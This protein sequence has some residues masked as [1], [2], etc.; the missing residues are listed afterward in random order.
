MQCKQWRNIE[1]S[2]FDLSSGHRRNLTVGEP[3]E[4]NCHIQF[5]QRRSCYSF[6]TL[7]GLSAALAAFILSMIRPLCGNL[8]GEI[9]RKVVRTLW[10]RGWI[11]CHLFHRCTVTWLALSCTPHPW[12]TSHSRVVANIMRLAKRGAWRAWSAD[13]G[14]STRITCLLPKS[15]VIHP[16]PLSS[17]H[18]SQG[19][20]LFGTGSPRMHSIHRHQNLARK[21]SIVELG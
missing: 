19:R 14:S 11:I 8:S 1:S 18:D 13:W 15:T 10:L 12:L 20:S 21:P 4:R 17:S 9:N 16:T 5:N 3:G 6:I 2:R 7:S